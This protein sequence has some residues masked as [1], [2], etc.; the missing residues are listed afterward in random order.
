MNHIAFFCEL[1]LKVVWMEHLTKENESP[2][3]K[4]LFTL[5]HSKVPLRKKN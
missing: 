2:S 4:S 5:A 3:I 1:S